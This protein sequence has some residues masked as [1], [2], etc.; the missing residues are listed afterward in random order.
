MKT[1]IRFSKQATECKDH[2]LITPHGAQRTS[3]CF[4]YPSGHFIW[5]EYK[6]RKTAIKK[7]EAFVASFNAE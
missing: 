2:Y 5:R 6:N 1:E 4:I 7:G 3:V